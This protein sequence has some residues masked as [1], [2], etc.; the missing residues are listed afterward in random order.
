MPGLRGFPY[1]THPTGWAL[2]ELSANLK[3]GELKPLRYFST[4]LVL[5][6][7]E[8]G[9][10]YLMDAHC[11]HNGAHIGYG[12]KV[13]GDCVVCPFHAWKWG[14]D[15]KNVDIPYSRILHNN[16]RMR[17]WHLWEESG[18]IFAWYDAEGWEPQWAPMKFP[19]DPEKYYPIEKTTIV[20]RNK[21]MY[22]QWFVENGADPAHI[23]YV[24]MA[25]DIP[26]W[27]YQWNG[28]NSGQECHLPRPTVGSQA[29]GMS[30][31]KGHPTQPALGDYDYREQW[32]LVCCAEVDPCVTDV[33]V[34]TFLVKEEGYP[35]EPGPR[36]QKALLYRQRNITL[37][38]QLFD[39][40][41]YRD[42]PLWPPEE[43]KAWNEL[44]KRLRRFYPADT[45]IR[46]IPPGVLKGV[47]HTRQEDA[48]VGGKRGRATVSS[49]LSIW[50][51]A[52][53]A[54][55]AGAE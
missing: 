43:S 34:P 26:Y 20:F 3:P 47:Q 51:R 6:R 50:T 48:V 14:P 28:P 46:E 39:S 45:G 22:A 9:T 44:R 12:G 35:D 27:D 24:H 13:D 23:K 32:N 49:K 19:D 36:A 16:A 5:Y 33:W 4:D 38:F 7:S 15:G 11:G 40:M 52:P 53:E 10:A 29:L 41:V 54:E 31:T 55:P 25:A 37:D 30:A 8:A 18:L 21:S 17:T 2:I 1:T 42:G